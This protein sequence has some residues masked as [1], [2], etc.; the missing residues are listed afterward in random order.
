MTIDNYH[1]SVP[2]TVLSQPVLMPQLAALKQQASINLETAL[3]FADIG[4]TGIDHS[5]NARSRSAHPSGGVSPLPS[6]A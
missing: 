5:P 2:K 6:P 3:R 4:P 1:N